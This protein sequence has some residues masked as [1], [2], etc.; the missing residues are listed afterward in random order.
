MAT[1]VRTLSGSWR[2][3]VRR[4]GVGWQSRNFHRRGDA[5]A[6]ARRQESAIERGLWHDNQAAERCTLRQALARYEETV[7]ARKRSAVAERSELRII[8][9]DAKFLDRNLAA[10]T[11]ADVAGLR[12][13]WRADGVK[14]ST[15]RRRM[16][17]LSH[18]FSVARREWGMSGLGNPVRD[19][20]FAPVADARS[21]RVSDEEL[22][23]ICQ[24]T[25]SPELVSFLRLALATA[26]RRGELLALEWKYVDL[27]RHVARVKTKSKLIERWRDVPLTDAA[28]DILGGIARRLDGRVFG[29]RADS[30]TQAFARALHRARARYVQE[31]EEAARAP[32]AGYL[33]DVR[34]HDLRHEATSR[35]SRYLHAQELARVTGHATLSMLMTYYN[36]SAT[37]LA[38]RIAGAT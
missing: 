7:T 18:L 12:D 9:S 5:E 34:I 31:C 37:E 11:G 35:L 21:R 23:A 17:P 24:A 29:G 22:T 27:A 30:Y 19:V 8:R 33:V 26:M 14:P 25:E 1:I 4:T 20:S 13:S 32:L 2:A 16:A 6:W 15:I 28:A 38:Q 10:I 3:R 36:P